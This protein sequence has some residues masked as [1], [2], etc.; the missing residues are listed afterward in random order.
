L[1]LEEDTSYFES[2]GK[3]DEVK[4]NDLGGEFVSVSRDLTSAEADLLA[5][6]Y[7]GASK[8]TAHLTSGSNHGFPPE[9]LPKAIELIS[10]LLKSHLYDK[11]GRPMER[12]YD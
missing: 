10:Q 7:N 11:A 4:V 5:R 6:T 12:H 2:G 1:H 8:A 9:D 3:S